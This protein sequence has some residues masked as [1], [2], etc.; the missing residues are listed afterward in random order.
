ML[1]PKIIPIFKTH[2]LVIII[3]T[4]LKTVRVRATLESGSKRESFDRIYSQSSGV[5]EF[6]KLEMR[7][8]KAL[9]SY[10]WV[11]GGG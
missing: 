5:L 9:K 1:K 10:G 11:V 2:P 3:L 6:S 4:S 8:R 7:D